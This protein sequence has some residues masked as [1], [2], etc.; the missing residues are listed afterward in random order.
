[1]TCKAA[2]GP[3]VRYYFCQREAIEMLVW[4]GLT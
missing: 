1:M 3:P 4:C 2:V